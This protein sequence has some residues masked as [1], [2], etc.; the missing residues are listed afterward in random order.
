MRNVGWYSIGK[1]LELLELL[2]EYASDENDEI[3]SRL[4]VLR[5][6]RNEVRDGQIADKLQGVSYVKVS[7]VD[8]ILNSN[9]VKEMVAVVG[10]M[11]HVSYFHSQVEV[12]TH[13]LPAFQFLHHCRTGT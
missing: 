10:V 1:E 6:R 7:C 11:S 12:V 9:G 5:C 13:I 4:L 3:F 2:D 8:S